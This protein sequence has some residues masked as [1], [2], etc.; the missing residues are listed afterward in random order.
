VAFTV[1]VGR[2]RPGERGMQAISGVRSSRQPS[3]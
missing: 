3:A 1:E 2:W